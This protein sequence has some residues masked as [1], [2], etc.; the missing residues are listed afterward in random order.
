MNNPIRV[1]QGNAKPYERFWTVKDAAETGGDPEIEFSG[2]ISEYSWFGDEITPKKFKEDLYGIGKGGPVTIRVNSGGG[3]IIAASVIR[4]TLLD[5]PGKKTVKVDGLAAS[6]A[7]AVALA[8]DS[9]KIFDTAYMMVHNPGYG[10]L[11]GYLDADALD[12]FAE[13]LRLF[14]EGILNA[15]ETR[16]GL[17]RAA[18]AKM[19]DEETWMTAQQAVELGFADEVITGGSPIR[20]D[21]KYAV[22]DYAHVP[23]ALLMAIDGGHEGGSN[24]RD[25]KSESSTPELSGARADS[26]ES[27]AGQEPGNPPVAEGDIPPNGS[28]L[29]GMEVNVL[30]ELQARLA[31]AQ[32]KTHQGVETMNVRELMKERETKLARAKA[33]TEA[34]DQEGRD[35]TETERAE[36]EALLGK[37]DTTGEIGALDAQIDQIQAEREKLRAAAEKKFNATDPEKPAPGNDQKTVMKRGEFAK[38]DPQAQQAFIK[39]GG[40]LED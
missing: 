9:V 36:F 3:E 37:G 34:A 12:K 21:V 39:A 20:K 33:I 28:H 14:R 8:G 10:L 25:E 35:L 22:R 7:V 31:Q 38:L 11:M 15:Y 2:Y 29:G 18:L 16:T 24:P 13:E 23:P 19:M 32:S 4:A 17:D 40:K 26:L 27:N 5:Y 1:V 6:A 30:A